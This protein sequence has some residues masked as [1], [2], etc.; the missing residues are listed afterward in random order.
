MKLCVVGAGYV[1]LVTGACLA[2]VGNEVF[3]IDKNGSKVDKLRSGSVPIFEPG[4]ESLVQKNIKEKRLQFSTDLKA[5]LSEAVLCFICVDT[6]PDKNGKADL[7]NVQLAAQE[8]GMTMARPLTLVTKSTVPVG[9]TLKVKAIVTE[10][11]LSRG[12][13]DGWVTV[14]SNPEFLKEG[15][16][17]Q[18]FLK[19][20]RVVV[21]SESSVA[22]Q[23]LHALYAPFMHQQ[24]RFIVMDILSAE[25]TKYACN[26]MLAT[27]ISFMNELAR[28][29]EKVGADIT[30]IRDAMGRDHRIGP[31]FLYPGLGY[32]GSCFPKDVKALIHIARD[33]DA[34]LPVVEATHQVNTEQP[35]WF[36][37][38][39]KTYFDAHGTLSQKKI[40][41][42]GLSF[43]A[44]TDDVRESMGLYMVELLL[45]EN[46]DV[47]VY[48]PVAMSN[49]RSQLENRVRYCQEL[50]ECVQ[51]VD[52]LIVCTDWNEFRS[53]N[54]ERMLKAMRS[55]VLFDG[56][57][58]YD[59]AVMVA[60]GFTYQGVGR[61]I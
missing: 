35:E 53:P 19:P 6:P 39:V 52:A 5:G 58:L 22:T 33:F 29:T 42:W 13:P 21:G 9:T 26:T 27:R 56:R 24:D 12:L 48:D 31:H 36:F 57:N 47:T 49:A 30:K 60:L 3:C 34:T 46:A 59:P 2:E 4:L 1:G 41:V 25:L 50:Y 55:A 16:A 32:G 38:K 45:K 8:I 7:T 17:V 51:G 44:N 43:K 23:T 14:A 54:Y 40:G 15:S 61:K 10:A 11:L 37:K 18:D 20:D 28:L